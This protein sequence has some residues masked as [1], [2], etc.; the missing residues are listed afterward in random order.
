MD[1]LIF[2]KLNLKGRA[3]VYS[4]LVV[5]LNVCGGLMYTPF[6]VLKYFVSFLV[7]QSSRREK[8]CWFY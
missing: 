1:I 6:F 4:L 2:I 5:A 3:D 8:E 7:L